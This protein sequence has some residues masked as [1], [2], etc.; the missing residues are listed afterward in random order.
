[1]LKLKIETVEVNLNLL[2]VIFDLDVGRIGENLFSDDLWYMHL[3]HKYAV[4][5]IG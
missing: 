3:Q 2:C 4:V 5:K 1:M